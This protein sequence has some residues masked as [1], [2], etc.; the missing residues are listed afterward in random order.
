MNTNCTSRR[1]K[2]E[3]DFEF[4]VVLLALLG[5]VVGGVYGFDIGSRRGVLAGFAAGVLGAVVGLLGTLL[6]AFLLA[7]LLSPL[8]ALL[9]RFARWWRP[10][11]PACENGAC[12]GRDAYQRCEIPEEV[13]K[14]V[15]GL[16]RS[17]YRC[18]CGNVYATGHDY[19]MQRRFLRVLPDGKI[20]PYLRFRIFGRWRADDGR[21]IIELPPD[22]VEPVPREIPGWVV[23]CLSTA[24]F[25]GVAFCVVYLSPSAKPHPIDPWFVLA[26]A[27]LGFVTGC[28]VWW[29]TP[30]EQP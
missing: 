28:V 1:R 13:V 20:R 9:E 10:Y 21:G 6:A 11:P 7:F 22:Y 17:G 18:K 15:R 23:P 25:G 24:I 16:C 3:A 4:M 19:G 8:D 5:A 29:R 12:A 27:A 30:K 14:R 26:V 2:G